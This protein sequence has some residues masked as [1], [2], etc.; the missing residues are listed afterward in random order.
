MAVFNI[1]KKSTIVSNAY[2]FYV[3]FA[4]LGLDLGL[5]FVTVGLDYT[6]LDCLHVCNIITCT[7]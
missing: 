5:G 6:T 3:S 7:M 4:G 2:L 1:D